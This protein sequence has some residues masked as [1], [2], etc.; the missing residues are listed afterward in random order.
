MRISN[1]M[2]TRNYLSGLN[3]A[4]NQYS[5]AQQ[6]M[7]SGLRNDRIS[8][9][10]RDEIFGLRVSAQ[11]EGKE[12]FLTNIRDAQAELDVA[13]SSL[14]S[15]SD[16][17][18]TAL[19]KIESGMSDDKAENGRETIATMMESWQKQIVQFANTQY[20]EKQLMNGTVNNRAPFSLNADNELL[21][22]GFRVDTIRVNNGKYVGVK[23]DDPAA[24]EQDLM[25]EEQIYIDLGTG[26][27]IDGNNQVVDP[28]SAFLLS[29][30]GLKCLGFGQ[31]TSTTPP[32]SK[33][34]VNILGAVAEQFKKKT[35]DQG[36]KADIVNNNFKALQDARQNLVVNISE[37]GTRGNFLET[38]GDRLEADLENLTKVQQK[39][40]IV[41]DTE[42]ATTV[43]QMDYLMN[44]NLAF[45]SK[46]LPL[47]LMDYLR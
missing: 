23:D 32:T 6:Q 21:Y 25:E 26:I 36:Y 42:Q 37:I 35:A 31:D 5:K 24:G 18:L 14:T 46:Y 3:K 9:N 11:M 38:T 47:S 30:D 19:G 28:A 39:L 40:L 1:N 12:Q 44:L 33:N 17:L 10:V 43:K 4:M 16:V 2:M 13:E 22:N 20:Q 15:I 8:G 45:G 34:V 29:V 27:R 41:S 7:T